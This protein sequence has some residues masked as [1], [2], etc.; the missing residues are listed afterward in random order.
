M[1]S[2]AGKSHA[3]IQAN[4]R[5]WITACVDGNVVFSKLFTAGT[6]DSI[7]FIDHAIVRMGN[8]GPVEITLDS[9]PVG[10][11][12]QMGQVRVIEL[13]RGASHFLVGG[14]AEDCTLAKS[15]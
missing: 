7:D 8:A 9:K 1:V 10:S 12:G 2:S 4:D 15:R 6:E 13:V 11:L 3:S 14:E 5:S